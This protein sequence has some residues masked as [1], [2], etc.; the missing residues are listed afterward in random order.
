MCVDPTT[1]R[2]LPGRS[3][4]TVCFVGSGITRSVLHEK[5]LDIFSPMRNKS[6]AT[7]PPPVECGALFVLRPAHCDDR[8]GV[9]YV[10]LAFSCGI[11]TSRR[12]GRARLGR[13]FFL[14]FV[15]GVVVASSPHP[16]FNFWQQAGFSLSCTRYQVLPYVS[17]TAVESGGSV[18]VNTP[19]SFSRVDCLFARCE[20]FLCRLVSPPGIYFL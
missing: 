5:D 13:L 20:S 1:A 4:G 2:R 18:L 14:L 6:H 11:R 8:K 12:K 17:R 7:S 9:M 16:N 10:S 3:L 15:G 19:L